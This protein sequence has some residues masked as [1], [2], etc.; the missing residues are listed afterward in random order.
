MATRRERLTFFLSRLKGLLLTPGLE[1]KE[2]RERGPGGMLL[3]R[4]FIV[5]PCAFLSLA[6]VATRWVITGDLSPALL[7]GII[8]FLACTTGC[9]ATVSIARVILATEVKRSALVLP[10]L[11]VYTFTVYLLFRSLSMAFPS[12]NFLGDLMTVM[13]LYAFYTLYTGLRG[14]TAA[15]PARVQGSCL[16]VGLLVVGLPLIITHLLAV[17]FRVP[18]VI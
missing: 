6:V 11:V 4:D 14:L 10:R 12:R 17:L 15:D 9:V 8:N 5:L 2:I 18:I 1:W 16:I 13:S 3:F 7:W